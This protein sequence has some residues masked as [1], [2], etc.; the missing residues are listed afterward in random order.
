M[1]PTREPPRA[2]PRDATWTHA[3][4][5]PDHRTSEPG[6]AG[7]PGPD[8]TVH[9]GRLGRF[10]VLRMLGM[11]GMGVVYSAYDELL[12]RRV[13]LKL[14]RTDR[15]GG[16]AQGRILREAQALARLSHPNVVPV[17]EVSAS[18]G[19]VFIAMEYVE[20][21]TLRAWTDAR[22]RPGQSD[23]QHSAARREILDMYVQAGR[24]LAAA[25]A[26]G[27]V[28]RD[29]KPDNVLVGDDGR[30]RVVDFGLVTHLADP[31][32]GATRAIVGTPAYM[33]P[34]QL[35]GDTSDARADQY[36]FCVA[37]H[38]ALTGALP[39]LC[40]ESAAP[41]R[42]PPSPDALPRWLLAV[43]RRGMA[44][45]PEDR[46]RSMN[47]LLEALLRDPVAARRRRLRLAALVLGS[48]VLAVGLV[49]LVLGTRQRWQDRGREVAADRALASAEAR[50][51]EAR[52]GDDP[53]AAA[54]FTAFVEDPL[55]DGTAALARAWLAEAGRRR[56]DGN[57]DAARAA[58]ATAYIRA[59]DREHQRDALVGLARLFR[60]GH[61]WESLAHL[62]ALLDREHPDAGAAPE[63]SALRVD[64]ALARRD[65]ATV[66]ALRTGEPAAV[67][68]ADAL[69]GATATAHRDVESAHVGEAHVLLVENRVGRRALHV[70]GRAPGLPLLRSL[71]LPADTLRVQPVADDPSRVI[72]HA[73]GGRNTLY[74][75][76]ADELA[77]LHRW[78][79]TGPSAAAAAD[80]DGDGTRELYVAT[81]T[82]LEIVELARTP[83]G[84]WTSR[85]VYT[86]EDSLESAAHQLRAIDLDDGRQGLVA[87]L[88]GWRAYDVRVLARDPGVAR[89]RTDAR[90]KLGAVT[91][92]AGLRRD[93]GAS[94]L[95]ASNMNAESSALFFPPDR[96]AGDPEGFYLYDLGGGRLTRRAHLPLPLPYKVWFRGLR[97]VGDA[98]GDGREDLAGT[99]AHDDQLHAL[100]Y[101]QRA[102][103]GFVPVTIGHLDLLAFAGLDDDPADEM[104]ANLLDADG[105]PRLHVLGVGDQAL[106][107]VD[108]PTVATPALVDPGDDAWT[109]QADQ[110]AALQGLGLLADAAAAFQ[111][112]GRRTAAPTLRAAAL[113]RAA[114]L[115]ERIGADRDALPLFV[116]AADAPAL[117]PEALQGALRTQLRLGEYDGADDILAALLARGDLPEVVR[118]ELMRRWAPLLAAAGERVELDFSG[119]LAPAW[120]LAE[121]FALRRTPGVEGLGIDTTAPGVLVSLP[122]EWWGGMLELS[123]EL[124]VEALEWSSLLEIELVP[125]DR[126]DD[127]IA[128][129]AL[130]TFGTSRGG[131]TVRH[132]YGCTLGRHDL[133][134]VDRDATAETPGVPVRLTVRAMAVPTPGAARCVVE[135][136]SLGARLG[137]REEPLL[138]GLPS[139]GRHRLVVRLSNAVPARFAARLHRIELRGAR[140]IDRPAHDPLRSELHRALVDED[141]VAA[142]AVLDRLGALTPAEQTWRAHALLAT[143]RLA[144]ARAAWRSLLAVPALEPTLGSL[145]RVH[146]AL[147]GP[148]LRDLVPDRYPG[149]LV[150]LWRNPATN[151]L[152][153]PRTR[154]ALRTALLPLDADALVAGAGTDPAALAAACDL[155]SWRGRLFMRTHE[156]ARADLDLR[157]AIAIA[158]RLPAD[159]SQ[160]AQLWLLWLDLASLAAATGDRE[161]ARQ[162]VEAARAGSDT[163]L[164]DD[165]VRARPELAGL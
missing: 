112:L 31:A 123:A 56:D 38:E 70:V 16:D 68:V 125:E 108:P 100:L 5:G 121:P 29:F 111:D 84:A 140:A 77:A 133:H 17:Y 13:A 72:A 118:D 43:L 162:A 40:E 22:R 61:E 98:D 124:T 42:S 147:Y 128:A 89:L 109:R 64:S 150:D 8:E 1:I 153:D 48:V 132:R 163:P 11:G 63:I 46:F 12:A 113:L 161:Q 62:L 92:L 44:V 86:A 137:D 52:R 37:L 36:S 149:L 82:D 165:V 78:G 146:P 83:A 107:P 59:L 45:L 3:P 126:P 106:T 99:F 97:A 60:D 127:P 130:R 69:V 157:R 117:A 80:L 95:V 85:V 6:G 71:S 10:V 119:P 32:P 102:S 155:L 19:R 94:L 104:I 158:G 101:L 152:D 49:F 50:I 27:L 138:D 122:V 15:Q 55:H 34:E 2:G 76:D 39:V 142:L 160:R 159:A 115:R 75:A 93:G 26:G 24:G 91:G 66:R 65:L 90:D 156:S 25:H 114:S 88:H 14:V 74:R 96:P 148:L 41:S 47:D 87:G 9:E 145:L 103:G 144:E 73:V 7:P 139:G 135:Q 151:H 141:S 30:A 35:V 79:G 4:S 54:V 21:C 120:S 51:A 110:A 28:H 58:F 129:L 131:I 57:L 18:A 164:L 67:A 20:G 134:H 105:V 143:G 23:P 116:A 136:R 81:G 53:A 154:H 33:P